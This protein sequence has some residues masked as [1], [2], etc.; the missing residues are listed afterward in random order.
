M[1]SLVYPCHL[2]QEGRHVVEDAAVVAVEDEE[3]EEGEEEEEVEE[4]QP[5][6]FLTMSKRIMY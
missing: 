6:M 4:V 5:Q 2:D 3:G 1:T